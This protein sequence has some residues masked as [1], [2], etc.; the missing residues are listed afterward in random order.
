MCIEEEDSAVEQEEL[1]DVLGIGDDLSAK[2]RLS[3]AVSTV[4]PKS[5]KKRVQRET[6]QM[7][8]FH[9]NSSIKIILTLGN[10]SLSDEMVCLNP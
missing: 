8:P 2:S 6:K 4:F 9:I 10:L 5:V 1:V 7:Y 3:R